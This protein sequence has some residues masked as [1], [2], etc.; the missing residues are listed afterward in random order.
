M[1]MDHDAA[2]VASPVTVREPSVTV[3]VPAVMTAGT[4]SSP[5]DGGAAGGSSQQD[6][7]SVVHPPLCV[8]ELAFGNGGSPRAALA[9]L[10]TV[11]TAGSLSQL[12]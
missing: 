7:R 3:T 6:P 4:V 1:V 10:S 9:M 8:Q 5:A 11:A 12:L 2:A